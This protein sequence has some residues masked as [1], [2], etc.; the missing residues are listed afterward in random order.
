[1]GHVLGIGT[2]WQDNG[3]AGNGCSYTSGTAVAREWKTYSGC[4][5]LSN[6]VEQT[7]STGTK[8]S[9]WSEKCF[10]DELMTG[11]LSGSSQPLSPITLAALEDLGYSVD[12]TK[13]DSFSSS[14]ISSSCLCNR[15]LRSKTL[16]TIEGDAPTIRRRLSGEGELAALNFGKAV[17]AMR[18]A[19]SSI[20]DNADIFLENV[21]G[22]SQIDIGDQVLLVLY[23]ENGHI[24][25]VDASN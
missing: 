16:M 24:F 10:A 6:L 1:M 14:D 8:C 18:K 9:H 21:D 11:Y 4:T 17:L 12:F 3:L 22:S 25:S 19:V 13:A 2:L 5:D 15:R 7:G 23:E 20:R